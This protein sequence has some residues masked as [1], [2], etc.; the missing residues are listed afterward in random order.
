MRPQMDLAE[1]EG[2]KGPMRADKAPGE[3]S[4]VLTSRGEAGACSLADTA[5]FAF[6]TVAHGGIPDPTF[7]YGLRGELVAR[8]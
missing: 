1:S 4:A 2:L 5:A 3:A 7:V 6:G 8:V